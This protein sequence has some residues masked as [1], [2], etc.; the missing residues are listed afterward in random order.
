MV[1][2]H[3]SQFRESR[4]ETTPRVDAQ[5]NQSSSTSFAQQLSEAF[6]DALQKVGID[7]GSVRITSQNPDAS[8]KPSQFIV[9]VK[10]QPVDPFAAA[11]SAG[12]TAP[13]SGTAATGNTAVTTSPASTAGA[14]GDSAEMTTLKN[15]LQA[16]GIDPGPLNIQQMT[17]VE[18]RP[19]G[20]SYTDHYFQ[21]QTPKGTQL[22]D[23][24]MTM[25]NPQVTVVEIQN[26]LNPS[27]TWI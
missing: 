16:A 22:F 5:N 13:A 23:A 3:P 20:G 1:Q 6:S 2:F 11:A 10:A 15:A 8:G 26:L 21:V 18:T 9:N 19:F 27:T 14:P 7:P 12:S 4:P 24:D 17:D 25:L